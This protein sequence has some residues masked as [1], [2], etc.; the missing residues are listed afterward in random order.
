M[1]LQTFSHFLCLLFPLLHFILIDQPEARVTHKINECPQ[2]QNPFLCE[3]KNGA[4]LAPNLVGKVLLAW[5]TN[6]VLFL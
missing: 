3:H 2:R 4:I 5:N 6:T 1:F